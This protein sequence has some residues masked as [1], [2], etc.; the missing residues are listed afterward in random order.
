M[1]K[2]ILASVFLCFVIVTYGN[3][4]SNI[5][6]LK[7][8]RQK[9]P[10]GINLVV[11]GPS[12]NIGASIDW[13]VTKKINL[14]VGSGIN[15]FNSLQYSGFFGARYHLFGKSFSNMTIY[16]GVYDKITMDPVALYHTLYL[17]IG[18]HRI[19]KSR[20]SWHLELA[21]QN[22]LTVNEWDLWGAFKVGYRIIKVSNIKRRKKN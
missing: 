13:F 11:L 18:I 4:P 21:Y 19:K 6:F 1:K 14:E 7:N 5:D 8:R 15:R 17:P 9:Y 2:N 12:G 22:N 3:S 20:L 10:V 16:G